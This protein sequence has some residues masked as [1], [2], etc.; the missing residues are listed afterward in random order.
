LQEAARNLPLE[1]ILIETDSPYLAPIPYRGQRN[2][3][4]YTQYVCA[5]LA[6][7]KNITVE[8]CAAATTANSF[9]LFTKVQPRN[10]A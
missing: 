8:E 9:T 5:Q 3:P 10:H 4:A 1:R 7:L 6:A 2:Q